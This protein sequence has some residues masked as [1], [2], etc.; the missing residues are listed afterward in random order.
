MALVL[1]R[2]DD[3]Q[4]DG[5]RIYAMIDEIATSRGNG[6]P[7]PAAHENSTQ[8]I[9]SIEIDLG[10][11]GAATGLG[12]VASAA[13]CLEQRVIPP[14]DPAHGPDYW[15][16]NRADGS[17]RARVE[18]SSLGG[19]HAVVVLEECDGDRQR[20]WQDVVRPSMKVGV[21]AIEANDES[22]LS[23]RL[24]ELRDL[25]RKSSA[26]D[27]HSFAKLWWQRYP[28]DP[29]LRIGMAVVAD[30][31]E[32][33]LQTLDHIREEKPEPDAEPAF[34]PNRLAFV[35]PGLGNQFAGM[36]RSS[37]GPL[38]RGARSPGFGDRL[39]ATAA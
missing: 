26:A 35:Y 24:Y 22:G 20:E 31:V 16:R 4:R 6:E 34:A 3:A 21:F 1:K 8:E 23:E 15:M 2:L 14:R 37:C 19:N 28:N 13:L 7:S 12:T 17:R 25:A 11:A 29:G 39:S 30:T 36:G 27:I 38:A 9:R 32:S 5:D 18:A 33:L 10:N